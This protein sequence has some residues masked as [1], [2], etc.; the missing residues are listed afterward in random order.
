MKT[1]V[2]ILLSAALGA[3]LTFGF[4]QDARQK[5]AQIVQR[6]ESFVSTTTSDAVQTAS[7]TAYAEAQ[8]SVDANANVGTQSAM[9]AKAQTS[10]SAQAS[11]NTG[12]A[13]NGPLF[14]FL[15]DGQSG[16]NLNF[17]FGQ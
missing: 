12:T 14:N 6:A 9:S 16:L 7:N 4:S 2:Q 1:I 5:A 3:G 15:F 8:T 17:G 10:T 11:E 13:G